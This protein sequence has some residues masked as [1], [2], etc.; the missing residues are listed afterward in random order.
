MECMCEF[1]CINQGYSIRNPK[2]PLAKFPFGPGSGTVTVKIQKHNSNKNVW[3]MHK[4][5]CGLICVKGDTFFCGLNLGIK[6]VKA[7]RRH[8]CMCSLVSRLLYLFFTIFMVEKADS[9]Q[10]VEVCMLLLCGWSN[11]YTACCL[12]LSWLIIPFLFVCQ[13][14][15]W[16][17]L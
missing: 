5:W 2:G 17:W 6:G 16:D 8:W 14:I 1:E 10:Y 15:F 11:Y 7:R 9:Q 4:R 12:V 13:C 3:T